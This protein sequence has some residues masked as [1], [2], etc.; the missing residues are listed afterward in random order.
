MA[1]DK[2]PKVAARNPA[3][4]EIEAGEHYWCACGL[5]DTQPFCN[6]NHKNTDITPLPFT[7]TDQK[8]VALCQCKQTGNA[9]FCDGSHRQ[10]G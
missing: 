8:K 4:L 1:S 10:L 7:I 3:I 2:I 5:S 9:P 6:G